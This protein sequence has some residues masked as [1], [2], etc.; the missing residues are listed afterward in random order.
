MKNYELT[1]LISSNLTEEEARDLQGRVTALIQEEGGLLDE[2][3]TLLKR[4][5][6]YPIAKQDQAY[7][8]VLNFQLSPE[9]LSNLEKKLKEESQ[10][11]RYLI[12]VKVPTRET[13]IPI[14][15]RI[16]PVPLSSAPAPSE[17]KEKKVELKEIDKK[18]EEILEENL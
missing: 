3:S 2:K 7:L 13:A 10:I 1:Y 15:R 18:L 4:R 17:P 8:S 11:L 9:K 6:A 16:Q 12:V 14:R 5:L